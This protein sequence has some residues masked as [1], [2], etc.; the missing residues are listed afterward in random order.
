MRKICANIDEELSKYKELNK[1]ELDYM[2]IKKNKDSLTA[3]T[4]VLQEIKKI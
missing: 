1:T 2:V 4:T 3:L